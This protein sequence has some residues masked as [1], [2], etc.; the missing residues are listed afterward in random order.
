MILGRF[1]SRLKKRLLPAEV[2]RLI[3]ACS[4]ARD[5]FLIVLLYN[6]GLR[7]GEAL[8]LHHIDI[9]VPD[10]IIWIDPHEDN[11]NEARVKSGR[12][13]GVPVHD[14]VI[15]MYVDYHQRSNVAVLLRSSPP[16]GL[17]PLLDCASDA[18]GG[19]YFALHLIPIDGI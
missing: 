4:L 15:N 9:D 2:L 11:D 8:D 7:V 1:A 3:D 13:R 18:Q 5:A 10:K 17:F 12:T 19:G 6:T 16:L 14:Y